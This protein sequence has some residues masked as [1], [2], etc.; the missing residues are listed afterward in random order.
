MY[1]GWKLRDQALVEQSSRFGD[2]TR[3]LACS[4]DLCK[5]KEL[6]E[7]FALSVTGGRGQAEGLVLDVHRVSGR[8]YSSAYRVHRFRVS[9]SPYEY[10][11]II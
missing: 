7:H 11:L 2:F 3:D 1:G 8:S 9:G 5:D 4:D 6:R 10:E